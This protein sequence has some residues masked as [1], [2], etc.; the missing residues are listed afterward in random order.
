MIG[1]EFNRK[2]KN[3]GIT[4]EAKHSSTCGGRMGA[5]D[6]DGFVPRFLAMTGGTLRF[7]H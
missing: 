6:L 5:A 4:S 2:K 7:S 3:L 1:K